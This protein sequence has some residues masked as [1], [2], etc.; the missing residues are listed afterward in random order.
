M[1]RSN[2]SHNTQRD[3]KAT[4]NFKATIKAYLDQRAESDILFSFKYS[5]PRKNIEDCV[6]YIL[7]TVQKSGCNGFSDDEIFG[8]AVHYYDE[9]NIDIGKPMNAHV[10][11]NH[12]VELTAEE[13]EQARQ[14]AI[15][16]AQD[17]AYRKM[18]QPVKKAKKVALNPQPSLFDF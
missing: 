5:V 3:M 6:T 18:I 2:P 13:K 16:K 9:D 1:G 17:E 7:N 14:D 11:V 8:M 10:V 15:Q 4:D 12:V